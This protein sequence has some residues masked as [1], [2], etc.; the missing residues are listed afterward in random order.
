MNT[1]DGREAYRR[2][3]EREAFLERL[4]AAREAIARA[5]VKLSAMPH[6]LKIDFE[7]L[8]F[9]EEVQ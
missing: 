5:E 7:R 3:M 1:H 2:S 4:G 8:L 9:G 6:G